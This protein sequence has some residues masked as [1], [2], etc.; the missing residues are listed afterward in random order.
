M[1]VLI[2]RVTIYLD[3]LTPH[4]Y[5]IVIVSSSMND[6]MNRVFIVG[7]TCSPLVFVLVDYGLLLLV[8]F[9]LLLLR[10]CMMTLNQEH[11][12][13]DRSLVVIDSFAWVC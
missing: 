5:S 9:V 1:M 12:E 4:V 10:H 2:H 8:G 6:R 3:R 7:V 13:C 11:L